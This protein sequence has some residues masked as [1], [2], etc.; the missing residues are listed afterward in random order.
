VGGSEEYITRALGAVASVAPDLDLVLFA[1]PAFS[2]AHP[3]LAERHEVVVSPVH[4]R[5]RSARVVVE[6]TWLPRRAR[7]RGVELVHH[8]GGTAP[9]AGGLPIVLSVHDI[10]YVSLPA[11]FSALKRRWL[12]YAVPAGLRRA[13]VVTVPSSFVRSTLVTAYGPTAGRVVVVPHGLPTDFAAKEVT[14]DDALRD[15]YAVPGPFVL[16]PAATY[17]HKNHEVLL[18][19]MAR[20]PSSSDLKL[21]LIGGTGRA[22]DAVLE[23]I[24]RRGLWPQV[25]RTGRV[26]DA[27]RDGLLRLADALVFPSRYE[28]FGA[29]VAE[30]FAAGTPVIASD[31]TA[32]PEVVG[33]AGLL[34]PPGDAAAWAAAMQRI[35]TD[36]ALRTSLI[37]AG[38]RRAGE[39]SA[40]SSAAALVDAYRLALD[41]RAGG[42]DGPTDRAG[43]PAP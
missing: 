5:R 4:G 32:L 22:E 38:R 26:S 35:E 23:G 40:H 43:E 20:L 34:L 30:A 6:R 2:R 9:A 36:Q 12:G 16:Y 21:V 13:S 14:D 39:L 18:D 11:N 24:S 42:A 19:A 7:D 15:R 1:L 25:V 3:D 37:A 10:Q 8:A 41:S 27:D 17:P 33:D 29:P 31:A 28:G